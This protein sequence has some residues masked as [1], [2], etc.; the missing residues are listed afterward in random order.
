[1]IRKT[2]CVFSIWLMVIHASLFAQGSAIP[3]GRWNKVAQEKPGTGLVVSLKGG[4]QIECFLKTL[5]TDTISV[6][7]METKEREIPKIAVQK[8]VT[9]EKRSGPLW[10]GAVIGAAIPA[11]IG[12][13]AVAKYP[14]NSSGAALGIALMAGLGA[15]IGVGIDAAT[16]G[17]ITLYKAPKTTD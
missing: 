9:S 8:I 2:V 1:M 10:N 5:S 11:T 16:R 4:E 3:P 17:Q 12:I 14:D 15:L 6:I 7:T 13:I